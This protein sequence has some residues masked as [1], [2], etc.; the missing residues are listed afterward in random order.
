M[1][2]KYGEIVSHLTAYFITY[3]K[4]DSLIASL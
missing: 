4:W 2:N 3:I 1:E